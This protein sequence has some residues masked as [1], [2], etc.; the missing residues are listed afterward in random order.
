MSD[1]EECLRLLAERAESADRHAEWPTPSWDILRRAG[2]LRW[3]IEPKF[4]GAGLDTGAILDG[5]EALAGACLTTCFLLSQ[6]EAAIRRIRDLASEPLRLELLA[7]LA[8]GTQFATVGLSQLTTSRQHGRPSLTAGAAGEAYILNGTV[9]WVTGAQC[10]DHLLVGA[11]M[12]DGQQV[13]MVV[14]TRL[15]GVR[16]GPP[17]DLMA[18]R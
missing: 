3:S 1:F 8:E 13:L 2:V 12:D 18:L 4:G 7:P 5:N 9:P 14:P 6:R 15:P 11:V 17:L 16:V 10:A